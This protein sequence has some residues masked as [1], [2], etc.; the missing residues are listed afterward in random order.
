MTGQT[1]TDGASDPVAALE[2]GAR[3]VRW[4]PRVPPHKIRR[5]YETDALGIVDEEQIDDVGYA[6]LARCR[7]I[8]EVTEAH[9]RGRIRCPRAECRTTIQ[10]RGSFA[11]D[12][13]DAE[14]I[15]CGACGWATTARAY[16]LTYRGKQLYG[17]RALHAFEPFVRDFEHAVTARQ[18]ML[19]ID[20]LIHDIHGD[21]AH[22]RKGIGRPAAVSVL[23][24]S[25][26]DIIRTLDAL[27]YGDGTTPDLR[28]GRARWDAT[29]QAAARLSNSVSNNWRDSWGAD[30]E[31]DERIR[32]LVA[33][34]QM[35]RTPREAYHLLVS[36]VDD[37][38]ASTMREL[39]S[40]ADRVRDVLGHPHVIVLACAASDAV[41]YLAFVSPD[42][43]EFGLRADA[44]VKRLANSVGGGGGGSP[45][46]AFGGG[47]K[48]ARL[49]GA[50]DELRR[51]FEAAPS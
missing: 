38:L 14:V 27:A 36:N 45:S 22:G 35:I 6:L 31:T 50:M 30:A 15:A 19:A 5:L 32:S 48:R 26:R 40:T 28:E 13:D 4:A 34:A 18:K 25:S 21:L 43:A 33:Q 29:R 20:R 23:E 42:L 9:D 49:Y 17:P 47:G 1:R 10:R 8:L 3:E 51:T 2:A 44:I 11:N 37:S 16:R 39:R 12:G 41:H 7:S 24:G 46:E